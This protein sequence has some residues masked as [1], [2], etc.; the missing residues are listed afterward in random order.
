MDVGQ[1]QMESAYDC[2]GVVDGQSTNVAQFLDLVRASTW[3]APTDQGKLEFQSLRLQFF[4]LSVTHLKAQ[5]FHATL[6]C[7]P[8]SDS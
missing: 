7:I 6:D 8:A 1:L 2:V 5:L 4:N 3:L